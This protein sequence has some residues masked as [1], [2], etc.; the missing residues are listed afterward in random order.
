MSP[1]FRGRGGEGEGGGGRDVGGGKRYHQFL[2]QLVLVMIHEY[3][4]A[5]FFLQVHFHTIPLL[6]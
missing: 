4:V 6:T 2:V 3:L 1:L 5:G